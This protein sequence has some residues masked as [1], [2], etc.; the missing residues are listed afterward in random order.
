MLLMR[1]ITIVVATVVLTK[2][3][4]AAA[5]DGPV[6]K[7]RSVVFR[8]RAAMVFMMADLGGESSAACEFT[9]ER[10]VER[11]GASPHSI[12][13][14]GSLAWPHAEPVIRCEG[15]SR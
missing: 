14:S 12:S 13:R 5:K 9:L 15:R 10:R 7:L 1:N 2:P 8:S 6:E 3:Q 4:R 11:G